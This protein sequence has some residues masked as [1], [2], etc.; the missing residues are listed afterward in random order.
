MNWIKLNWTKLNQI[1][2]IYHHNRQIAFIFSNT[3]S[4]KYAY[5]KGYF[6][7][8]NKKKEWIYNAHQMTANNDTRAWNDNP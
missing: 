3:D 2:Y 7:R 8:I 4:F 5:R 1:E 6:L